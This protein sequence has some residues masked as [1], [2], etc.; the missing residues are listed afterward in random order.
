MKNNELWKN[1]CIIKEPNYQDRNIIIDFKA[2]GWKII[3]AHL[4]SKQKR[5]KTIDLRYYF[6]N[7]GN[8]DGAI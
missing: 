6:F 1:E 4:G 8:F 3:K 5:I 7:L 2:A